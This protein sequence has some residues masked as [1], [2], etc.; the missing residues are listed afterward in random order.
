MHMHAIVCTVRLYAYITEAVHEPHFT[1]ATNTPPTTDP[2]EQSKRL[3]CTSSTRQ[4]FT[5]ILNHHHPKKKRKSTS[6]P[7]KQDF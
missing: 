1:P 4:S 3:H 6:V 7:A 5:A 2:C